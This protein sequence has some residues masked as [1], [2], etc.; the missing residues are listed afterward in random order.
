[1][2]SATKPKWFVAL[3][4]AVLLVGVLGCVPANLFAAES[5]RPPNILFILTDDLGYG[6]LGCYG[7]END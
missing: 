6:E 1:M 2:N 4:R 5:S 3:K 7:R